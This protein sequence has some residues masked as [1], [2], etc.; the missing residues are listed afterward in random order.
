MSKEKLNDY[1]KTLEFRENEDMY[2][3]YGIDLNI[4][5]L[6]ITKD[7]DEEGHITLNW[8]QQAIC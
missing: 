6:L 3:E 4:L 8:G 1:I 5:D 7:K 2:S